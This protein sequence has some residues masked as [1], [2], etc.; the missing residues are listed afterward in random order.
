MSERSG[1][2]VIS[3][4]S[5]R[6]PNGKH[7]IYFVREMNIE[8]SAERVTQA[9]NDELEGFVKEHPEQWMWLHKRWKRFVE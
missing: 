3:V 8:G 5:I 2:P 7:A 4:Y 1:A 9:Y 6:K